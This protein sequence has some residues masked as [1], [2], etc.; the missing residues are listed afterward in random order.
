MFGAGLGPGADEEAQATPVIR[1]D[2]EMGNNTRTKELLAGAIAAGEVCLSPQQGTQ[3][4]CSSENVLW[5]I[6]VGSSVAMFSW[7]VAEADCII[8]S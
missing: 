6:S 4:H 1:T 8:F 2:R 3:M 5:C 7:E